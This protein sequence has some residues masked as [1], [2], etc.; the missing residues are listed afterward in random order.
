MTVHPTLDPAAWPLRR[1]CETIARHWALWYAALQL[2][3][4]RERGEP[5]L[6]EFK[7]RIL[8][9]HHRAHFL[10]GLRK[11]GIARDLPPAVIAGR[12]HYL[13]NQVGGL[14]MEYVEES[15]RKVWIRYLA[16]SWGFPGAGLFAVPSRSA[17]AVFA[18]WHAHNG[19]SL[20]CPRLGFVL[21]KLYQDGEPYDEGYF[22]EFDRDLAPEERIRYGPVTTSPD[23]DPAQ[24]PRLDPVAWPEERRWR[25]NRNF[26]L[27]Y[28]E[29]GIRTCLEML[30]VH[31]TAGLVAQ[32][33]R[34]YAI[35]YYHELRETFGVGGSGARELARLLAHLA[36]L[37]GEEVSWREEAPGR[38]VVG[39]APRLLAAGDV[40]AEIHRAL[41]AFPAMCARLHG[42]RVR[43]A[44]TALR[45][46]GAPRD[47]WVVEDVPHRLF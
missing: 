19:V 8:Y 28:V 12:Y 26:A 32:A 21:T 47:E 38:I 6:T 9:R 11:L 35:Q 43:V 39:H 4:L 5:A 17:R 29:D 37:A 27:G 30:G 41:F 10:D 45:A 7:Y 23:F 14:G 36:E 25:A 46:E 40:P 22:E 18:G 42:A 31:L 15:P 3:L 2:T 20:G 16:P 44:L 13:S 24:A 33:L 1:R 34:A